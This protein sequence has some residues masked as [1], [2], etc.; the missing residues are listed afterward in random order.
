M[1]ARPF[2]YFGIALFVSAS[3][4]RALT[5]EEILNYKGAD[6]EQILLEGARRE[7]Q[8]TLYSSMIANQMLRPL[9]DAFSKKYPFVKF[10][11]WRAESANLFTKLSAESRA[12]NVVADVVEGT[13]VG[14]AV[15]QAGLTQAWSTPIFAELPS[16]YL[17]KNG[18]W[19]PTRRSFFGIAYNTKLTP[20]ERVPKTY[21]DLLAPHLKGR[22][23]WHAGSSSGSDLFVTNLRLAWGEDRAADF[24]KRLATQQVVNMTAGSARLLVDRVMAGEMSVALN[25]FAHHPLISRAKGAPVNSQLMDPV[26]STVGTMVMPKGLRHPHAAMLLADFILSKE[27]QKILS[28]AEYFPVRDDVAP[29]PGLAPIVEGVAKLNENFANPEKLVKFTASSGQMIQDLFR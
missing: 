23:A 24:M 8:V 29:L 4:A 13:G 6:R 1:R 10:N 17:D 12:N 20:E 22:M 21:E 25:I 26:A 18:M 3:S 11:Y 16:R 15:V 14:E 28:D 7:G 19:A 9:A 27:G 5:T 2:A